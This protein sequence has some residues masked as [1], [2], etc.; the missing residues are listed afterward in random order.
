MN[1]RAADTSF[2]DFLTR[3]RAGEDDAT[4]KVFHLFASRLISISRSHLDARARQKVDPED[5]TQSVFRTFFRRAGA[6]EFTF[7]DWQ[8]IWGLLVTIT[9]RK[10]GRQVESLR[11]ARRDYRR[12]AQIGQHDESSQLMWEPQADTPTPD[13]AAALTETIENLMAQLD[14]RG[15]EVLTL[16]LQGYTV[17]EISLRIGRTERT[18]FRILD[19][20]KSELQAHIASGS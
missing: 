10:C 1:D 3:L 2:D 12:E 7:E 17:P 18:V 9:M 20:I 6:G 5:V 14:E 4:C 16:R 15:R 8:G 11:A 19:H 13:E